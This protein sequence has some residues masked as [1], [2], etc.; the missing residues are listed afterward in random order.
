MC[1]A[2]WQIARKLGLTKADLF[3]PALSISVA[4]NLN[5][6]LIGAHFLELFDNAGHSTEQLVYFS[7]GVGEFYLSQ[8]ALKSLKVIPHNFPVIRSCTTNP[9][10]NK[11]ADAQHAV[12]E[13]DKEEDEVFNT[14]LHSADIYEVH[15]EF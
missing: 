6:E 13:D 4:D 12:D 3:A 8:E 15:N 11:V 1:V 2:D 14:Q 7:S 9:S 5:L 10:I